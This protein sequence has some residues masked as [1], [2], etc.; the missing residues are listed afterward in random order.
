MK[1]LIFLIIPLI[2]CSC[3]NKNTEKS[4]EAKNES[5]TLNAIKETD[6]SF[7][8][9]DPEKIAL[10]S[11]SKN[12]PPKQV[13]SIL[14]DYVDKTYILEFDEEEYDNYEKVIDTI[15]RKNN[16]TK[17]KTASIIFSYQYEQITNDEIID[18]YNF[19]REDYLYGE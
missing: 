6:E 5:K 8:V 13:Y 16:L 7:F 10:L 1:K 12:I 9:N 4:I 19:E 15:A 11:L 17:Q 14:K 2:F 3:L 18:I